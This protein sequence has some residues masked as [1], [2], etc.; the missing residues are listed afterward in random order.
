MSP[1]DRRIPSWL[2]A[3][4]LFV[5]GAAAFWLLRPLA[6]QSGDYREYSEQKRY[7]WDL[8]IY[9]IREPGSV[10]L[11]QACAWGSRRLV[12]G[13]GEIGAMLDEAERRRG[14][15]LLG[16]F[17]GGAFVVFLGAFIRDARPRSRVRAAAAAAVVLTS[18]ITWTFVGHI[19]F[20]A[21]FYA[22][23]MFFYWRV[24]RYFREPS[25]RAFFWMILGA[26][27]A[28]GMHRV[29]LF[30]LPALALMWLKPGRPLAIARPTRHQAT[31]MLSLLIAACVAHFVPIFSAAALGARIAVF[32]DYNWLPELITPLTQGWADYVQ[33]HSKLGSYHLFTFGSLAHAQHFLFF[34]AIASPLGLPVA[35]LYRKAI[36]DAG[37]RFLL[38]ASILGWIWALVWHPHLGYGDWDLFANPGLPTNLLAAWLLLGGAGGT[39]HPDQ[40]G[41]GAS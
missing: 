22:G 3:L 35:I 37:A 21:P 23:L 9:H 26:W 12:S 31:V 32:E 27:V 2:A 30:H 41:S 36:R 7:G 29:A 16:A 4:A 8:P 34:V 24:A 6:V 39:G 17:S 25:D 33:A 11:W 5:V 10:L 40:A 28:V 38:A 19:E 18:A 1:S 20:Y 15:D 13:G 14:F